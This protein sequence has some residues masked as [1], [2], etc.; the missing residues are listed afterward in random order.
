VLCN[1]LGIDCLRAHYALRRTAIRLEENGFCV[2]RFDYDGTGDSVGESTDPDRVGAWLR[3][4]GEAVRLLRD[5]GMGWI[6]LVGMRSGALLAAAAS[7]Q[8]GSIDALVLTDPIASGRAFVSEQRAMAAM[9]VG[10]KARR[11]DG[12]V[13]TPGVVY[14]AETVEA[15]KG[16]RI[17]KEEALPAKRVLVLTRRGTTVDSGLSGRLSSDAVEW[18]EV[19]GQEGLIDAEAPDQVLPLDDIERVAHWMSETAPSETSAVKLPQQAGAAPVAEAPGGRQVVER[20]LSLGPTGLFGMVTEVPGRSAGPAVVFFNVATEPH[21]GPGRLW[22]QLARQWA[23]L[24]L[25]SVRVDVSGLGESPSRPGEP[26]FV[27]RLPVAFDDVSE[28]VK[29][30]SPD[31]PSDVVLVGLCSSAYQA[32]DS[33][34]DVKPRGVIALNPVLTFQPPE[35]LAGGTIS[36]RRRVALARGSVIQKFHHEGPLAPL[37][38]RFPN[39]AWRVRTLIARGARPTLW[40]KDL[41]ASGVDL[42]LICGDREARPIRQGTTPR[43]LSRLD[44]TGLFQFEFIPGLQHGLLVADHR[45]RIRK[46]VTEHVTKRFAVLR[47]DPAGTSVNS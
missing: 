38:K 30:V 19:T 34:F 9:A 24:G 42:M 28:V 1:P 36:P 40:L 25:R 7:E 4:V 15:L 11:D 22:V 46:M 16:L 43:T 5:A 12:S 21:T 17:G 26:E 6:A 47:S 8:D 27:I 18:G 33:A 31:D 23:Q 13:E 20:P 10:V 3:S 35:V 29:A 44:A 39:L 32:L 41:T 14:D 37:R 45:E 2:V